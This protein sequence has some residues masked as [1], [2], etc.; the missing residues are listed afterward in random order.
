MGGFYQTPNALLT[1]YA[2]ISDSAF[3]VYS[4]LLMHDYGSGQCWPSYNTLAKLLKRDRRT[5]MRAIKE[6]ESAGLLEVK[7]RLGEDGGLTSN[8]YRPKLIVR[9]QPPARRD[10]ATPAPAPRKEAEPF[11]MEYEEMQP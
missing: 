2:A 9:R 8:L 11:G 10:T 4:A 7:A 6:L 1:D 3:R 5:I